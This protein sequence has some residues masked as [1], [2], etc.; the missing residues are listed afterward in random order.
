MSYYLGVFSLIPGRGL[1]LG[2]IAVPLGISGLWKRWAL[3]QIR[4]SL[5]ALVGICLGGLSVAAHLAV[6]GLMIYSAS[7]N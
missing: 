4:G 5:H 7:W 1:L 2:C 6:A 3:P